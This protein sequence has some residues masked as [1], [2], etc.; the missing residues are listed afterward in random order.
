M[1][2]LIVS[3]ATC[4][5][6]IVGF[7]VDPHIPLVISTGIC[8]IYAFYLGR[9]WEIIEKGIFDSIKSALLPMLIILF[10]GMVVGGWIACGTVPYL[11]YWGLKLLS[12]QWFLLSSVIMCSIMSMS[13]GSS[14]TTLGTLGVA[15]MG[16]GQGLGIPAPMTA[17]AVASGAFYGDKQSP[18]SDTTNFAPAVSGTTL[19]EH[20]RSMLYTTT[21]TMVIS[22]IIFTFLGFKYGSGEFDTANINVILTTLEKNFT[23][24]IFMILPLILLVIMILKK[25]PALL[26]MGIAALIGLIFAM[27]FQGDSLGQAIGYLHY[28]YKG[29]TGVDV[30]DKLLT[31]GGLH[32]M[33]WT[34]SLMF[35]SLAMAGVLQVTGALLVI[36]EKCV[37]LIKT[38]FGLVTTTLWSGFFL[39]YFAADIY[40]AMLLPAKVFGPAFDEKNLDRKVLSRTI[41]D[42]GTIVAP[43]V[44]WGTGGVYTA[45]TLGIST[46]SYA[47]FY[48]LGILNPFV[49]MTCAAIGFGMF[50]AVKK[51]RNADS[52]SH[53]ESQVIPGM[54]STENI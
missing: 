7:N 30:V 9:P 24:N 14:W 34:I 33:L 6:G 52:K 20:V 39:N 53:M 36:L 17:G 16:V 51:K 22:C 46:L 18:L 29:S 42:A 5:I 40:L 23:L 47:P 45:A 10:I 26:A 2:V 44:P 4:L 49:S 19:Y 13:I 27:I 25:V 37:L 8:V 3:F 1:C 31:R 11:I 32:S 50:K 21:P 38:R 28:G 15:L 12:P 48:L 35:I 54:A 43:L 41:E